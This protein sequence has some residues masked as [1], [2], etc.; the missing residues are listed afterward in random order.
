MNQTSL[1][2]RRTLLRL[3]RKNN[4]KIAIARHRVIGD[5]CIWERISLMNPC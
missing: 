4:L 3:E 1:K 2:Q 5:G